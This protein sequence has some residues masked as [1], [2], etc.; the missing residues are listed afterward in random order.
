MVWHR[1]KRNLRHYD[2]LWLTFAPKDI[3]VDEKNKNYF[4][5]MR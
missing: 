4:K 3:R 5:E 1:G 2:Y